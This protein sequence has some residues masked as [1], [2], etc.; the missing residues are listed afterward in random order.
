MWRRQQ[1]VCDERPGVQDV[2][3]LLRAW[4]DEAVHGNND[5]VVLQEPEWQECG[6]DSQ[7]FTGRGVLVQGSRE[8]GQQQW[9]E[10]FFFRW[11][12]VFWRRQQWQQRWW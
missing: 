7:W 4:L 1:V 9:L 2:W 12:V 10:F 6:L 8:R 5:G 3:R 11:W